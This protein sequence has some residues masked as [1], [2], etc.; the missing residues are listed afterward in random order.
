MSLAAEV[1]NCCEWRGS[2][3]VTVVGKCSDADWLRRSNNRVS[4]GHSEDCMWCTER[5]ISRGQV[6]LAIDL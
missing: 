5:M 6:Q 3:R 4:V 2:N 1:V